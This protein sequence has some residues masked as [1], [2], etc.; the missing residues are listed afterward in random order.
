MNIVLVDDEQRALNLLKIIVEE[1]PDLTPQDSIQYFSD[2]VNAL[3]Y[4]LANDVD[5][6]FIDIEMPKLTGIEVSQQILMN[7][8]KLPEG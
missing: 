4:I 8:D 6:V 7:K 2:S 1:S 5:L 3:S